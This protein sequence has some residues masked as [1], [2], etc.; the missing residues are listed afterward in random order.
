[1]ETQRVLAFSKYLESECLWKWAPYIFI[2]GKGVLKQRI[3]ARQ[4][5]IAMKNLRIEIATFR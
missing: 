1:M 5:D 3:T 4:Y 2:R